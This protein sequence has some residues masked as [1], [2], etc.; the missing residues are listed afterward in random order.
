MHFL[1]VFLM[2]A[3]MVEPAT[4]A[5]PSEPAPAAATE[6]AAGQTATAPA[7][8]TQRYRCERRAPTGQRLARRVC[9]PTDSNRQQ[10]ASDTLRNIQNTRTSSGD[11]MLGG[12]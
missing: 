11:A 9:T 8:E 3:I 10:Q 1:A 2:Q 7:G 12:N 6:N 4:P 5:A